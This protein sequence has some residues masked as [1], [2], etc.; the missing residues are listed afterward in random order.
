[1]E[2]TDQRG[3]GQRRSFSVGGGSGASPPL[4]LAKDHID[5][6]HALAHGGL[7]KVKLQ[8]LTVVS[9]APEQV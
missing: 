8:A 7:G 5:V 2:G 4:Q 1:L 3:A 9:L 6:D